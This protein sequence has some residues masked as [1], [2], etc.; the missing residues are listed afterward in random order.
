MSGTKFVLISVGLIFVVMLLEYVLWQIL[1]N[2]LAEIIS[3]AMIFA[4]VYT[5]ANMG[6]TLK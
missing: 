6:T 5:I 3:W 1:P 4:M 2:C